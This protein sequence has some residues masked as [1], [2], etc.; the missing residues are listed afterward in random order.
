M[1]GENMLNSIGSNYQD[2]QVETSL[3]SSLEGNIDAGQEFD[4]TTEYLEGLKCNALNFI[5]L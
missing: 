1:L 2:V 3:V 5:M 4:L